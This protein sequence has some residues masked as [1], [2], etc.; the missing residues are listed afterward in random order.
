MN[1]K[2]IESF[3]GN[4]RWLSN[5]WLA[6]VTLDGIVYPS[7]EHAY[8]AAKTTDSAQ[9][10]TIRD[11]TTAGEAKHCGRRVTVRPNWNAMKLTYMEDFVRQKF[12]QHAY[13]K[14]N[15]LATGNAPLVEGNNWGDTFWGVCKG[16]GQNH[17]GRILMKIREELRA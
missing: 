2:P 10:S 3:S 12:T 17:L 11:C 5:F 15:L 8:Q 14:Q 6:E 4:Y 9:R 13:L 7:V 1:Q 16:R